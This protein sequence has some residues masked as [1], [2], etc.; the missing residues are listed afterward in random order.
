[1]KMMPKSAMKLVD[2][3]NGKKVAGP[4]NR[5][6]A[7]EKRGLKPRKRLMKKDYKRAVK[8]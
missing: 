3:K 5:V 6:K 2:K 7:V 4:S 8:K 1:M